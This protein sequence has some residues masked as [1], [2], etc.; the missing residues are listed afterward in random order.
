ML[1]KFW[2]GR[3]IFHLTPFRFPNRMILMTVNAYLAIGDKS[4]MG[5]ATASSTLV[6]TITPVRPI[7]LES[8][9]NNAT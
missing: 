1:R 7:P 4:Q 2:D 8:K 5:L 6:K 9:A 3:N